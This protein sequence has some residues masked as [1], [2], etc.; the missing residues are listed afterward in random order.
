MAMLLKRTLV[1]RALHDVAGVHDDDLVGARRDHAEVVGH[2][3]HRHLAVALQ[4]AQQ[5]EDLGLHG[6]VEPGG[7]LVGHE[8]AGGAGERDGDHDALAHATG[9]L[10]RV[11]LVA[12]DRGGDAHLHEEGER[13]LLG[14]SLGQLEVDLEGLGDL[15]ADALHRVERRHGVLEDHGD[16][17]APELAQLV[18]RAR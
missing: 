15:V 9:E 17:G 12:L 18:V 5:V 3:D 1:G 8:Q 14:L 6:H 16:V 4:R 11:G 13:R 7:G 2:Q 10:G